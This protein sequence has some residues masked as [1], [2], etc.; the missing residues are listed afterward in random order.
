MSNPN[1][2]LIQ[3]VPHMNIP[4]MKHNLNEKQ[5]MQNGYSII[6]KNPVF[7]K[8]LQIFANNILKLNLNNII[9]NDLRTLNSQR[10]KLYNFMQPKRERNIAQEF[11]SEL[12]YDLSRPARWMNQQMVSNQ[13]LISSLNTNAQQILNNL[14]AIDSKVKYDNIFQSIKN[15]RNPIDILLKR[16]QYKHTAGKSKTVEM[17]KP[18]VRKKKI[19]NSKSKNLDI[20]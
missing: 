4:G 8:E 7:V 18:V 19:S 11:Y 17:K 20:Y 1:N 16:F 3:R 15:C 12:K 5:L 10:F 14:N 6:L 13:Y 9:L 2:P